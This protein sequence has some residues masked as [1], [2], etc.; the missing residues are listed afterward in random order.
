MLSVHKLVEGNIFI[1]DADTPLKNQREDPTQGGLV[2]QGV[3]W[4]E[5]GEHKHLGGRQLHC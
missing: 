4:G 1:P 2:S 5:L 3:S